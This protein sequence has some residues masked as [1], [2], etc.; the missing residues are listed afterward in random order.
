[1]ECSLKAAAVEGVDYPTHIAR[2]HRHNPAPNTEQQL[3]WQV[4]VACPVQHHQ[5]GDDEIL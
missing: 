2:G 4:V 3:L 5:V 1:V